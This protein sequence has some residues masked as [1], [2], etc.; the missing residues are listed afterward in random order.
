MGRRDKGFSV[1]THKNSRTPTSSLYMCSFETTFS[2]KVR[3]NWKLWG[4]W[5]LQSIYLSRLFMRKL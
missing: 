2:L 4:Q 1:A 5:E 3:D